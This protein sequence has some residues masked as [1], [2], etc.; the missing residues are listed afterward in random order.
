MAN[1]SEYRFVFFVVLKLLLLGFF[2]F[3]YILGGRSDKWL[4]RYFGGM[5]FGLGMIAL[6][7]L[8]GRFKWGSLLLPFVYPAL[9]TLD[10]GSDVI[11]G[12]VLKRGL[13]GLAFG[14][15]GLFCGF[16]YGVPYLGVVQLLIAVA[17]SIF[18]GVFN[19]VRAVD[20]EAMIAL[21][22]TIHIPFML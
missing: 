16:I 20:E 1:V 4:R 12:K 10:Y 22:I 8:M 14:L 9:L 5:G 19:P 2:C 15:V 13:Y 7:L 21:A 11:L 18:L 17:A 6:S 3:F